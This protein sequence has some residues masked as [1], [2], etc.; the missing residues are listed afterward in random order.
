MVAIY[1][2][3]CLYIIHLSTCVPFGET[4]LFVGL[5]EAE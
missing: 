1:F 4:N 2:S 5:E 3:F